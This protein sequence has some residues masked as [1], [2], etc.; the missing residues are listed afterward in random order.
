LQKSP[1]SFLLSTRHPAVLK[2]CIN[3]ALKF[4]DLTPC[5]RIMV[6]TAHRILNPVNYIRDNDFDIKIIPES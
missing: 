2:E 4:V 5:S 1:C 3:Q 6:A